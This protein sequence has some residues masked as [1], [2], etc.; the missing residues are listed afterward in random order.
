M[1]SSLDGDDL[2]SDTAE[3]AHGFNTVLPWPFDP[4]ALDAAQ[5]ERAERFLRRCSQTGIRVVWPVSLLIHYS[6]FG[7]LTEQVSRLKDNPAI[8]AWYTGD[9]PDGWGED[10]ALLARGYQ[11]IKDI[12]PTRP[13]AMA[14]DT[15]A[16]YKQPHWQRYINSTDV[17]MVDPCKM[18]MLSRFAW[19]PSR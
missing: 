5:W 18:V 8:L 19:C 1:P 12:D 11:I 9:E 14:F 4:P 7:N 16:P 2:L 15:A 3:G 17:V 6:E 10:P 13:V